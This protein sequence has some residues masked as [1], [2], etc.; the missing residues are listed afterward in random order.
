MKSKLLY[1]TGSYWN[2]SQSDEQFK[3]DLDIVIEAITIVGI[4]DGRVFGGFVRN[5]LVPMKFNQSSPG[6]K[7]VDLWFTTQEDADQFV[8]NM[9]NKLTLIN[10]I[11]KDIDN[12]IIK[13]PFDRT[14]FF[15][16]NRIIIDIIVCSYLPVDDWHVNQLTFSAKE[17]FVSF[18][19]DSVESL[20]YDIMQKKV[21]LLYNM[22]KNEDYQQYGRLLKLQSLG[23]T[24]Y[25][26][27]L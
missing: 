12:C 20:I 5:V 14:V 9:G 18:G 22:P 15:L 23:W 16:H 2:S 11:T 24:I 7:D 27:N 8:K 21:K 4:Y 17:K 1:D 19:D 25:N 3:K 13:Y 26:N 10:L 6:Y